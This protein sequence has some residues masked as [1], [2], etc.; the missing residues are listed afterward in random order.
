MAALAWRGGRGVLALH[1]EVAV[2]HLLELDE[3]G[4]TTPLSTAVRAGRMTTATD[5][6]LADWYEE[7]RSDTYP[8][9]Q[10]DNNEVENA[11]RPTAVGKK[12][13]LFIG[14]PDAGQR[15]AIIYSLVVSCQ[16]HGKDLLV[17]GWTGAVG[18]VRSIGTR[19]AATRVAR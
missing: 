19:L 3:A 17:L 11:I 13:W 2:E 7:S 16:R 15:S 8:Y 6:E 5:D 1:G 10:I 14:H 18:A 12:N 4:K 9:I